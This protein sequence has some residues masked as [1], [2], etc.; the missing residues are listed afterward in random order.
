MKKIFD[1]TIINKVKKS[2]ER[3]LETIREEDYY[4][5]YT[6]TNVSFIAMYKY[7][8][9]KGIKN[10]KFFLKLYDESLITV[11][12]FDKN[13]TNEQKGRIIREITINPWYYYR[14]IYTIP[15]AGGDIRFE[16]NRGNLALL[17]LAHLN[18][19]IILE[20]PRQTGKTWG[21]LAN[22]DWTYNFSGENMSILT[23]NKSNDDGQANIQRYKDARKL[24][25][26]YL[27]F[28]HKDDTDNKREIRSGLTS[29][30]FKLIPTPKDQTFA[31][32]AGRGLTAPKIWFDEVAFIK[33]I[34]M[35]YTVAAPIQT[36]ASEAAA[37]NN[38]PYGKIL[39]TT[40]NYL[41][42]P[43][44]M[45]VYDIMD[46]AAKWNEELYD[47]TKEEIDNYIYENSS[48]DLIYIRYSWKELGKTEKWYDSQCRAMNNDH[49]KIK[50][51]L[52][53]EWTFASDNSPF[54]EEELEEIKSYIKPPIGNLRLKDVYTFDIYE[55]IDPLVSYCINVDISGGLKRDSTSIVIIHPVTGATVAI[56]NNNRISTSQLKF[57][58]FEIVTKWLLNGFLVIERNS[59]GLPIIQS[60]MEEKEFAIIRKKI[61]YSIK[62]E[63]REIKYGTGEKPMTKLQF[64]KKKTRVYGIDT[65]PASR[66]L[67]IELL[68][69]MIR[70]HPEKITAQIMFDQ[71]KTLEIKSNGKIEHRD[72]FNDDVLM[73]RL[74]GE[75]AKTRTTWRIFA[76]NK[77]ANEKAE[78]V[79]EYFRKLEI[80]KETNSLSSISQNLIKLEL[81]DKN[82]ENKFLIEKFRNMNRRD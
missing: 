10:N 54:S 38:V 70:E 5:H 62:E 48:N 27:Q 16:L 39:T 71:I 56:F 9:S 69:Q 34:D 7:L 15:E 68:G 64:R 44:G 20:L 60:F 78:F 63:E 37:R 28:S 32:K 75:Y 59:Y 12:P 53:L 79:Q 40:P 82:P 65:T 47:M 45:F 43:E 4:I 52:D 3:V 51:E 57:L 55:I 8:K 2:K 17:Y 81:K 18:I 80:I 49:I 19:N 67:F 42:S 77:T 6:T 11:N 22:F 31:D 25:P 1:R 73:A 76:R 21:V 36:K 26:E 30:V 35:I 61:F 14:E 23:M 50:R 46:K 24:L 29:N 72:G 13:L 41:D 66:E 33:Y 58:L 74:F